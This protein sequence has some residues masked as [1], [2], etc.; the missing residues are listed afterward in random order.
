M[1]LLGKLIGRSLRFLLIL[2]LILLA[3]V[4]YIETMCRG[5]V[6]AENY[7]PI[8][9]ADQHRPESRTLLTYP[10]W[11]IVH[12]YDDYAKV[13]ATGD[14]HDFDYIS[15]VTGFWSS[16]CAVSEQSASHGGFPW[17]TKQ[18]VYT[19]GISFSVELAFKAAYEESIGR[20]FAVLRGPEHSPL[21]RLSAQQAADYARFLQQVPWH[22]WDF[23]RDAAQLVAA[24][25]QSPRDKERR[26]ALGIE[27]AVKSAYAGL[28]AQAVENIGPDE[29][30][31]RSIVT[32][33]TEGQLGGIEGV[34][35]IASRPEGLE[36]ETPR[37]RAF[38][39]ILAALAASGGK[40]VEV[41]GNDDILFT[42]TSNNPTAPGAIF[43]FERQGYGDYRHLIFV[44]LPDLAESLNNLAA[45]GLSLEH[46][47]DY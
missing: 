21:D 34:T 22:Q 16:L 38:T 10:E 32:G 26:A 37:Y 3:P 18:M 14:P 45:N 40:I 36:I 20:M 12:A 6:S 43:S 46:I 9:P 2:A 44:K 41:A 1:R 15:S 17:E 25:S 35:V 11:H 27:F 31:I 33:L 29:L 23:D 24:N 8:L 39:N 47:H 42:A 5:E 28:I 7:Q 4:G 13:I 30:T 19:I